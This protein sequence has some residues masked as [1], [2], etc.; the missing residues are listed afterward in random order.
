MN[1]TDSLLRNQQRIGDQV[2][3]VD[4]ERILSWAQLC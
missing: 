2:A 4:G 1:T 3:L